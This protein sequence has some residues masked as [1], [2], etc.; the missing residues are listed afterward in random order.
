MNNLSSLKSRSKRLMGCSSA[1]ALLYAFSPSLLA[2][3][4]ANT[5]QA[6]QPVVEEVLVT[7]VRRSLENA[8]DV[9]RN[10]SSIVDHISAD[11]IGSLPALDLGE[12]L[13]SIPGIQLNAEGG[14]RANE[15]NL[16]GLPGG[17]V[18]DTT[19]GLNFAS[20]GLSRGIQGVSNPFGAFEA[21]I[22]RGAT[23]VKSPTAD[24]P[25]GGIAGYID[26][27]LP[28][29]L[30]SKR[31]ALS[32]NVGTRYEELA[33]N[34]DPEISVRAQKMLI[35]DVLAVSGTLATSKQRFRRD[36]SLVTRYE[37]LTDFHLDREP[38][39]NALENYKIANNIPLE[40]NVLFPSEVRQFSES[41]NGDRTSVAFNIEWQALDSLK[42]GLDYIGTK[43]ALDDN[44]QDIFITGARP[45]AGNNSGTNERQQVVN[46]TPLSDPFLA[47]TDPL[48]LDDDGGVVRPETDNY[49]ISDYSFENGPYLPGTRNRDSQ[50]QS[51]GVTLT[52]D[53]EFDEWTVSAQAL[54]SESETFRF[55]TQFDARYN[56]IDNR[57]LGDNR[58]REGRTNGITG[59]IKSGDGNLDDFLVEL[60][61]FENLS[62]DNPFRYD[63]RGRDDQ[64]WEILERQLTRLNVRSN[65][66]NEDGSRFDTRFFVAGAEIF[67]DRA[68]DT[69]RVDIARELD[70]SILDS[71]KFGVYQSTEDF[72]REVNNY[73]AAFINLEG[74]NNSLLVDPLFESGSNFFGGNL[75]G[76]LTTEGGLR[77]ID[78][79]ATIDNLTSG[80]QERYEAVLLDLENSVTVQGGNTASDALTDEQKAQALDFY[81]NR[82]KITNA[83][84]LERTRAS[85][86]IQDYSTQV[87]LIEAYLMTEFSGE[88][89][90]VAVTGNVGVR[91]T[92]TKNTAQGLAPITTLE[93]AE[94][95]AQQVGGSNVVFND[96]FETVNTETTY[97]NLLPS[98]NLSFDLT[99]DLI[100]R[101]A[102]YEGIVRPNAAAFAP[103]GSLNESERSF[104][105]TLPNT[106]LGPFTADSF[107]LNLSWYN[108]AGSVFSIGYFYKDIL[109]FSALEEIC[110]ADGSA[111][112]LGEL[113][114]TEDDLVCSEREPT[115][116]TIEED[117][118]ES[119]DEINREV[120]I[121][122]PI[123]SDEK[124]KL[125][126]LEASIQQ[127]L[128]FLPAPWGN[129]GGQLNISQVDLD[130][131]PIPNVSELSYNLI[132]YYEDGGF[133]ARLAYN[134]RDDYLLQTV[135]TANGTADRQAQSRERLDLSLAYKVN[136]N[137]RVT[138]RGF[139]LLDDI[140][141]EFQS[142]NEALPRRTNYDGRIYSLSANYRF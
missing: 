34:F 89:G 140:F 94:R 81:K 22:F 17:F 135:S 30:S 4:V 115:Q 21:A 62:L 14:D 15:I 104:S 6:N 9:K 132:T 63:V 24:L 114:L 141:Q 52:A 23:V 107:D 29:A 119:I 12:A 124:S 99:P 37:P 48:L 109:Q 98:L 79:Q 121:R 95:S 127:N 5:T 10:A 47:F 92:E 56:S 88:I 122:S 7:G 32:I 1:A 25:A 106:E 8:L 35:D 50:E 93:A 80:V 65:G 129:F 26:K 75:P 39:S 97:R 105:L 43:R 120:T 11:D 118:V 126:G 57:I 77:A 142:D 136:K 83:G 123:I 90:A 130:G 72:E 117:G 20:V 67:H 125:Q 2:Q 46:I 128:D 70:F 112:G 41:A 51:E 27:K 108:R 55:N 131:E 58:S 87:D 44:A 86:F 73:T 76:A 96:E 19:N 49:V 113:F 138:L 38:N 85:D 40:D 31:D 100:L 82:T 53:W 68:V 110:P 36:V 42:L 66:T 33:D 134:F 137:L 116:I 18:F 28:K 133:S 16:R 54:T 69:F 91:Y 78:V 139:N 103:V 59:L 101:T 84:F 3:E 61:G 102:Y 64:P 60:G 111:F 45:T 74:I 13:Q 71:V